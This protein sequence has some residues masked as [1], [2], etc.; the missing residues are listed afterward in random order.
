MLQEQFA[1][2]ATRRRIGALGPA[3]GWRC[4]EAGAGAGSVAR[5]LCSLVGPNG[6]VLAVDVDTRFMS[7]LQEA[8]LEVRQMDIVSEDLPEGVFDF[9]HARLLLVHLPA[10]ETVIRKI[11]Q[12]LKPGGWL[13]LEEREA[14]AL[15]IR[16]P[17]LDS[18]WKA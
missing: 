6:H 3:L 10:R 16:L 15:P 8:N 17:A 1:D 2:E 9:V 7:G 4:L 5:W 14:T 13:R 11:V 18:A 12:S